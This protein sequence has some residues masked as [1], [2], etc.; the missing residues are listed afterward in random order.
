MEK[1]ACSRSA[2]AEL[3]LR[4]RK[5]TVCSE[6]SHGCDGSQSRKERE[7]LE[8]FPSAYWGVEKNFRSKS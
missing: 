1:H 8:D 5:T 7:F 6:I 2:P 3:F 4:R